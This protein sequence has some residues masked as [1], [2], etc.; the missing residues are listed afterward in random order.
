MESTSSLLGRALGVILKTLVDEHPLFRLKSFGYEGFIHQA[1]LFYRLAIR[2]P[3]KVLVADE[4]G[5]GKTIEAL[6]LIEWGLRKQI[7]S[8]GRVL[9][10]VPRCLLGQWIEEARRMGLR[11]ESDLMRI[12]ELM[13]EE[14]RGFRVFIFKIDTAKKPQYLEKLRKYKW[15]L[16][17]V[18]EAHKLSVDSLRLDLVEKLVEANSD[19]S[20]ILLSATPHR[21]REE[22]YLALLELLDQAG[23]LS[24]MKANED[25]LREYFKKTIDA[26]VFRRSKREINEFYER[27]DR[28]G[29]KVFVDA[30]AI[31]C[32]V[33]LTEN[34]KK[35]IDKLDE[36]TRKI[37]RRA[38]NERL[39]RSL[40]LVAMVIDKR[41][42]SSPR[43]GWKTLSRIVKSVEG[44]T[45]LAREDETLEEL[46]EEYVEEEHVGLDKDKRIAA[47]ELD[48]VL[49]SATSSV[50][51]RTR[52][53]IRRIIEDLVDDLKRLRDLA[54]KA[55][56]C[57][58]KLL[59]LK[60]ILLK[61]LGEG[62]KVVVFTEFA[63]TAEYVFE[64]LRSTDVRK[65]GI[66]LL[67]G[68]RLGSEVTIDRVQEWLAEQGP[69]VLIS[70]D[71]AAEGLNL[72]YANVVINYELSW[73]LVKLEQ[74]A[75]RVWRLGQR[76]D[77]RI[78]LMFMNH[79]F[80]EKIFKALYLKLLNSVQA[81]IIPSILTA[82]GVETKEGRV[83]LPISGVLESRD[84]TP[85]NIW[86]TYKDADSP[87]EG[88]QRIEKLIDE[89]VK[90]MFTESK[91]TFTE[92]LKELYSPRARVLGPVKD[93]EKS[94]LKKIVGFA[95]RREFSE[96]LCKLIEKMTGT[97]CSDRVIS[98]WLIKLRQAE[99]S[100]GEIPL[101]L[102]CEGL[103]GKSFVVVAKA[104]VSRSGKRA[105]CW[106]YMYDHQEDKVK[107]IRDLV[108]F[109][110]RCGVCEEMGRGLKS[111]IESGY[112]ELQDIKPA[113]EQ[114]IR[115]F[116]ENEVMNYLLSDLQELE[117]LVKKVTGSS[118]LE[119]SGKSDL[120]VNV[121]PLVVFMPKSNVEKKLLDE[122]AKSI[123]ESIA[124]GDITEEKLEVENMGRAFL[125]KAL[126]SMY[127]LTYIGDTKAPFDYIAKSR[128][129]KTAFIELK[130]LVKSKFIVCTNN[131]KEFAERISG[132]YAYWL[133]VVEIKDDGVEIRGYEEPFS[134]SGKNKLKLISELKRKD[135]KI[136]YIYDEVGKPDYSF[137]LPASH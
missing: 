83:A 26:I 20:I 87:E 22:D 6:M 46:L 107:T 55:E 34:E 102:L 2:S 115:H 23:V 14:P 77:V 82:L 108:D 76:K 106:I 31:P 130:T 72:Q 117:E 17:V 19:A 36:I 81:G 90:K 71:V 43:A 96:I 133:F 35:Y 4:V 98:D 65:Y 127:E 63:D 13:Q 3:I 73:S 89:H 132:K 128:D 40:G 103:G 86:V 110:E 70:T 101:Y 28:G 91:K 30:V 69:R 64:R 61:H 41:G 52:E 42:L 75:G 67:T 25:W 131:E 21:G 120:Y 50:V 15:D 78:Y 48:D 33:E 51:S 99:I 37:V 129:G 100:E 92:M 84:L 66:E 7:F 45:E 80:E 136:Y 53:G 116:I 10:L 11:A 74:R 24:R 54:H 27:D 16:I 95:S 137:S 59:R 56:E 97:K 88:R 112:V 119:V 109:I 47:K 68:K 93:A 123:D 134:S 58:S 113:I 57:D 18:D 32:N 5:L 124:I 39:K 121:T 60:D 105:T 8:N 135:G 104:C 125:E 44:S 38:P 85:F 118:K 122:I 9:I 114:K 12:D 126:S 62:G 29:E 111:L 49:S 1:E 79:G 94:K